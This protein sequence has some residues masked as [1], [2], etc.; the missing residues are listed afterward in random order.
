[1]RVTT[2]FFAGAGTVV[3]AIGAGLGGGLLLGDIMSPQQPKQPSSEMTRLEQRMSPQPIPANGATQPVPYMATTQ[4]AA[5]IG[6]Q[7]AQPKQEAPPPQAQPQAQPQQAPPQVQQASTQASEPKQNPAAQPAAPA[8]QSAA[9]ERAAPDDAF[10]NARDA[11]LKRDARRPEDR[12]RRKAERRQ[13][14]DERRQQWDER[15]QQWVDKRKWR[16]R[17]DDDLN[18]VETSV[19]EA[20]ESRPFFGREPRFGNREPSYGNRESGFATGR[21]NLFDD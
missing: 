7:A 12:D 9:R 14:W 2:A 3:V 17:Q 18:D 8:D 10:A 16:P 6:E 11:D 20:T 21:F 4:V 1:M 15:R 13:Q 5:T 19:R